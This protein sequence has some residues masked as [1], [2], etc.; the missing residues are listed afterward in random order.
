MTLP[1]LARIIVFR[2]LRMITDKDILS[3]ARYYM[4][5][6]AKNREVEW[7]EQ[8]TM[9][10]DYSVAVKLHNYNLKKLQ[11]EAK[12]RGESMAV[13]FIKPL[14]RFELDDAFEEYLRK[15]PARK[16]V[17]LSITIKCEVENLDPI[18]TW[19]T[20]VSGAASE[21]ELYVMAHWLWLV[22]RNLNSL[23]V[24]Y[25][26]MPILVSPQRMNAKKQGG[27]KSTAIVR[28]IEP[29]KKMA[30][31][32]RMDQV[33]D[34]RAFTTFNNFL[35]GF[36]DELAGGKKVIIEDFKRIVTSETLTYRPMRTNGQHQIR[37]LC[38]FIGASNSPVDDVVQDPTGNRRFFQIKALDLCDQATINS[39]NYIELW[40][41]VNEN[42]PR[43][44]Y[45]RVKQEVIAAQQE[46]AT[47]ND[48][49]AF[50]EDFNLYPEKSTETVAINVQ[51][52]FQRYLVHL[53]TQGTN[54][55]PKCPT[56]TKRIIQLGMSVQEL[57]N[58]KRARYR[59]VHINKNHALEELEASRVK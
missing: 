39:I 12:V 8:S 48:L 21:A 57:R 26:I 18:K 42:E 51:E 59:I 29:L 40:K 41:G 53:N 15:E 43:G 4:E 13:S 32:L 30:T 31:E 56:F 6:W 7:N 14:T 37:N 28:L 34:D 27:G 9:R 1:A 49:E 17:K 25:H 11:I 22:K 54:Y 35:I 44:Y 45:E 50:M 38:S 46:I 24:V 2:G 5:V 47:Q 16:R 19:L 36:L 55:K 33:S 10:L 52:L 3:D 23:P 58:E 20:A